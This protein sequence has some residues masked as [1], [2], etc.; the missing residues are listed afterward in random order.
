MFRTRPCRDPSIKFVMNQAQGNQALTSRDKSWK[1]PHHLLNLFAAQHRSRLIACLLLTFCQAYGYDVLCR[2][3]DTRFQAYFHIGTDISVGPPT[4][5]DLAAARICRALLS[6]N[7]GPPGNQVRFELL[8]QSS[9]VL[10][11]PR[12]R[13]VEM[14]DRIA[15][16]WRR[17]G[18][19]HQPSAKRQGL[20]I[21]HCVPSCIR[22]ICERPEDRRGG[23][24]TCFGRPQAASHLYPISPPNVHRR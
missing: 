21:F 19:C 15:D 7:A 17:R 6:W 24:R 13:E 8:S 9:P 22:T 4:Q 12:F 20:G 11:N 23:W 5:E 2:N 3:G 18:A 1:T 10:G 16:S 14:Q